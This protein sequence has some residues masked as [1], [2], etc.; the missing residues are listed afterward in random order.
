VND[1]TSW[2]SY[3]LLVVDIDRYRDWPIKLLT[4]TSALHFAVMTAIAAK[5]LTLSSYVSI[6]VSGSLV[7][8][9]GFTLYYF[10]K[11]H[12]QYLALRNT[13]VRLNRLLKLQELEVSGVPVLPAVWFTERPVSLKEG[14]WGWGFYACYATVMLTLSLIVVWQIGFTWHKP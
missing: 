8:L 9:Y 2:E 1:T 5:E 11:C 10:G 4:F 6:C 7:T 13:Q 14:F 3:R 12:L